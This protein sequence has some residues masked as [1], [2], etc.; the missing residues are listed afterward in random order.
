MPSIF[1]KSVLVAAQAV[2]ASSLLIGAVGGCA[3]A[4]TYAKDASKQGM[5]L[6][7]QG[8]YP[9]AAASFANATRQNPQ[10]YRSYYYMGASYQNMHDYQ[11]AISAYRSCLDVMPLTLEGK[12]DT[13]FHNRTIDAL[14]TAIS[15]SQSQ[16]VETVALEKKC[17]GKGLVEDQWLLAKIYR[18]TGDADAA[19]DAY[20]KAVLIDPS[21]FT[22]AK[23]AG[24]YEAG[25]GQAPRA[26][27]AL[28][29]AY[30][31][32]PDDQQVNAALRSLG[33]TG[34]SPRDQRDL[35]HPAMPQDR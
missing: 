34:S 16:G 6:Y 12:N 30:A 5:G 25:L 23:E 20:N 1:S 21:N 35:A 28:K 2:L 15:K 4:L 31:V 27:F 24:L 7:N 33:V 10:D 8:N 3:D 22:I 32:N 18:Y 29:K 9:E 26:T 11:Q 19:I 13:P 14:A 17:A